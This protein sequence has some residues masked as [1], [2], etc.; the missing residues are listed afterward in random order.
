MEEEIKIDIPII[1]K[2]DVDMSDDLILE[3]KDLNEPTLD[4]TDV[5]NQTQEIILENPNE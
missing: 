4:L 5:I 3:D 2:E 1:N